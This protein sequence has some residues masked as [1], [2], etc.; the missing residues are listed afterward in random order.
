M[1]RGSGVLYR[2][3]GLFS[4][5]LKSSETA[6]LQ[7]DS[8]PDRSKPSTHVDYQIMQCLRSARTSSGTFVAVIDGSSTS[9]R[10][11]DATAAIAGDPH[12]YA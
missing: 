6:R 3:W 10:H 9:I 4:K 8:D 1:R 7:T 11:A 12:A 5:D 2:I